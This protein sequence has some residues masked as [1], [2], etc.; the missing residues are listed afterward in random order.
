MNHI[1]AVEQLVEILNDANPREHAQIMKRIKISAHDLVTNV[2]WSRQDYTRNCLARTQEYEIILL[3]W[4]I[5]SNAPIHGHDGKECWMYQIQGTVQEI[6]FEAEGEA[7]KETNRMTLSPGKLTYMCDRMG[8]HTIG[9][10]SN[11]RAI[12]LHIYA[13]PIDK[14]KVF[15]DQTESFELKEMFYDSIEDNEVKALV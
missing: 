5:G 15:N 4:D 6:R 1:T 2:S 12:T 14:C 7:L 3:C 11:E 9:N 8:Y 13:S 10:V